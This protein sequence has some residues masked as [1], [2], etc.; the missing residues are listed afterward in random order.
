M[1]TKWFIH[2]CNPAEKS[3]LDN[4]PLFPFPLVLPSQTTEFW[5]G[6]AGS[7]THC[8]PQLVC[9]IASMRDS[10]HSVMRRNK[11][12]QWDQYQDRPALPVWTQYSRKFTNSLNT[13]P[14]ISHY[15]TAM[16]DLEVS[17]TFYISPCEPNHL[18]T[19]NHF[20]LQHLW[21]QS[22]FSLTSQHP[23]RWSSALCVCLCACVC[24][25][26]CT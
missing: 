1:H 12:H 24:V 6:S 25:F 26:S 11:Q 18:Q 14:N 20:F 2:S 3:Y 19:S 9:W 8:F 17:V 10:F 16:K 23:L 15:H 7:W 21:D 22:I 5:L 13:Q 4:G